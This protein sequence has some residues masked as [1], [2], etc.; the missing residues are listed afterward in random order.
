MPELSPVAQAW[1]Q[2]ILVW[3]GFGS[4]AG[5]LARVLLPFREPASPLA[6]L[7]LGI[8]GSAVGL[9]LLSWLQNGGPP[10]PISPIGFLAATGGAL[11]LL[12]LYHLLRL[13]VHQEKKAT[14]QAA[15]AADDSVKVER[16]IANLKSQISDL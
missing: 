10:N 16:P 13:T 1:L 2:V 4:L 15:D 8:T 3:I 5:L 9:G 6:P 11:G 12:I 14:P 7:T